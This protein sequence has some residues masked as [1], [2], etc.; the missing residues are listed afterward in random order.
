MSN[1][2]K[3]EQ[4]TFDGANTQK[5]IFTHIGS[6]VYTIRSTKNNSYYL[7]I[8][9]DSTAD[10]TPIALRTGTVTNGMKWKVEKANQGYKIVSYSDPTMVL[11]T[12]TAS[13]TAGTNLK[14][15]DFQSGNDSYQDEWDIEPYQVVLYGITNAG[16]DH[17]SCLNTIGDSISNDSEINIRGGAISSVT[18]KNDLISTN[19]FTSRSHGYLITYIGT[20]DVC[21]TGILLND[22]EV[23]SEKVTFFS[24]SWSNIS[25]G[26]SYILPTDDYSRIDIAVFIG[27][28]TARGKE[29]GRNL[30]SK[31]VEKGARAAVG[32]S[33]TIDC[34]DAN[35]WTIQLYQKLLQ[36][37]SLQEAV[38]YACDRATEDSGL[39]SAVI[40]GDNSITIF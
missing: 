25:A 12:G 6:N 20:N 22:E 36:G 24:H 17:I 14:L 10:E 7:G 35:T 32:F 31:I 8:Q 16:H 5:W 27:C 39:K 34:S 33:D 19:L 9:N 37:A 23:D 4:Q 15:S 38:D 30:P 3:V 26:S 18:C 28:N 13:A 2:T 21:S 40:C 1:G 29:G 11:C